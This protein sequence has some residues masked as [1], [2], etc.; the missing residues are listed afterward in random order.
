[1]KKIHKKNIRQTTQTSNVCKR[2]YKD[3]AHPASIPETIILQKE[4][5]IIMI[6]KNLFCRTNF[7]YNFV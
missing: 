5:P 7:F 2:R 4:R 1:M 3:K 6:M